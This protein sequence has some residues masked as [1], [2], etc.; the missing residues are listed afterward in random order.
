MPSRVRKSIAP[1]N[2]SLDRSWL[3][4][5]CPSYLGGGLGWLH[6]VK[7]LHKNFFFGYGARVD[8]FWCIIFNATRVQ[9]Y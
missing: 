7:N 5:L 4:A 1:L 8:K 9:R 6:V 2:S 3:L